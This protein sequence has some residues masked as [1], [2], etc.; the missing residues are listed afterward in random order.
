MASEIWLALRVEVPSVSKALTSC[1]VPGKVTG[2]DS[3]PDFTTSLNVKSGSK[4]RSMATTF[5]PLGRT[6]SAGVGRTRGLGGNASGGK[7]RA[8]ASA[9]KSRAARQNTQLFGVRQLAA[10]LLR[11]KLASDSGSSKLE[12]QKW[13]VS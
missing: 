8:N 10:A 12:T 4:C 6:R 5:K 13:P 2:S 3:A 11:R 9:A 7:S 1:A